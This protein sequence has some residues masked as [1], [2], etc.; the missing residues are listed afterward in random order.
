MIR[1]S[2]T[3]RLTE[4]E[5]ELTVFNDVKAVREKCLDDNT[6]AHRFM[7]YRRPGMSIGQMPYTISASGQFDNI[8]PAAASVLHCRK[9][10]G[11]RQRSTELYQV[12]IPRHHL[13]DIL[14]PRIFHPASPIAS[15][16]LADPTRL[17]HIHSYKPPTY[18][19]QTAMF[20]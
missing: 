1:Q 5:I 16:R 2:S 13:Q 9:A 12:S 18:S 19:S 6:Y 4:I 7:F 15:A 3:F 17:T 14:E 11:C 20:H 10:S 8:I